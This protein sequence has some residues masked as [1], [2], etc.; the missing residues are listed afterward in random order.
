M[1]EEAD[2]VAL[3]GGAHAVQRVAYAEGHVGAG[4]HRAAAVLEARGV[5]LIGALHLQ[6]LQA[7]RRGGVELR[8]HLPVLLKGGVLLRVQRRGRRHGE[9]QGGRQVQ[10]MVEDGG[11]DTHIIYRTSGRRILMARACGQTIGKG[12]QISEKWPYR[13]T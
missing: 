1:G 10:Q 2:L 6:L 7:A 9:D 5:L 13:G 8:L 4:K 3:E 12:R 11:G